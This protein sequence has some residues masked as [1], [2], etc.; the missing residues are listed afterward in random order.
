MLT[1]L[2]LLRLIVIIE[3]ALIV[4]MVL[5]KRTL[6]CSECK[7]PLNESDKVCNK[8]GCP[9][10]ATNSQIKKLNINTTNIILLIID[11]LLVIFLGAVHLLVANISIM[12]MWQIIPIC[13][14]AISIIALL[15]Q[16]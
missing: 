6:L 10:E 5:K 8:C 1:I 14:M 13:L 11:L 3:I 16:K 12:I 7:S 2:R 15:K 9:I 4:Y